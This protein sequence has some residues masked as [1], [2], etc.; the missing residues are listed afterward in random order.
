MK[1]FL[2]Q[3]TYKK[4]NWIQKLKQR[5]LKFLTKNKQQVLIESSSLE[6]FYKETLNLESVKDLNKVQ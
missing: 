3:K 5:L 4:L 2:G 1:Y 6:D